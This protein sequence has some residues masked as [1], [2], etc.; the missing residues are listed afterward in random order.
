MEGRAG[1]NS[2]RKA[3][4]CVSA[5]EA[6]QKEFVPTTPPELGRHR[7]TGSDRSS[8]ASRA[9]GALIELLR[10]AH[11]LLE[12]LTD[13]DYASPLETTTQAADEL[14]QRGRIRDTSST[15]STACSRGSMPG[16]STTTPAS[17]TPR[18]RPSR[19]AGRRRIEG[20]IGELER[21]GDLEGRMP[22]DVRPEPGQDWTRSSLAREI[23]SVATHVIHHHALIRLT[24]AQREIETPPDPASRPR[25][26]PIERRASAEPLGSRHGPGPSRDALLERHGLRHGHPPGASSR[27]S[28]DRGIPSDEALIL[29]IL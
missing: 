5:Y 23:Q 2:S 19:D 10:Q 24:L 18:S 29:R 20:A 13:D 6:L 25:P 16:G 4:T 17:A 8:E 9:A 1:P 27:L 22:I 21:L 12:V 26:S 3:T 11:D 14:V 7:R 15:S 28:V